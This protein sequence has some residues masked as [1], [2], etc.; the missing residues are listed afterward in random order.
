[1]YDIACVK[2]VHNVSEYVPPRLQ[3]A[4]EIYASQVRTHPSAVL[5]SLLATTSTIIA[6]KVAFKMGPS[7]E[8]ATGSALFLF[9]IGQN[10]SGKSPALKAYCKKIVHK[11]QSEN[12]SKL[13]GS[14]ATIAGIRLQK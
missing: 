5:A 8:F 6:G 1:M 9:M 13:I 3:K 7:V 11:L 12:N 2:C 4:I 14:P 10:G